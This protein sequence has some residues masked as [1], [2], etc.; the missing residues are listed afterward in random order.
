M[1][2]DS[3]PIGTAVKLLRDIGDVEANETGKI[4]RHVSV[5][6]ENHDEDEFEVLIDGELI[7]VA[8][9]DIDEAS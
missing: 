5:S 7:L 8:R 3:P 9:G 4:V 1:L 6:R 2:P